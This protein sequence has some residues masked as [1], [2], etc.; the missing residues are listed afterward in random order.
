MGL[1][2]YAHKEFWYCIELVARLDCDHDIERAMLV[3]AMSAGL[4]VLQVALSH[5]VG[6][7]LDASKALYEKRIIV[8][9][10]INDDSMYR[11]RTL[12]TDRHYFTTDGANGKR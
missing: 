2:A 4:P 8:L 11:F 12:T 3:D 9:V 10:S 5:E 7:T 1:D 6:Y